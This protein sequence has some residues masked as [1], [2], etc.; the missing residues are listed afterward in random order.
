[1]FLIGSRF[2]KN[3]IYNKNL[4]I[5][6]CLHDKIFNGFKLCMHIIKVNVN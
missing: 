1:M 3:P 5:I 2:Y 6:K 4:N